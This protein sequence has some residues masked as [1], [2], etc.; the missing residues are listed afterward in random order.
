MTMLEPMQT[1]KESKGPLQSKT[2]GLG[3]VTLIGAGIAKQNPDFG[4]WVQ[5]NAESI[6]AVVGGLIVAFRPMSSKAINWRDMTIF[7]IGRKF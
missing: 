4:Q 7:G 3:I 5:D 2:L 1:G 6:L